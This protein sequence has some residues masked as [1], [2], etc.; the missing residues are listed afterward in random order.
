MNCQ[1]VA[2]L[3]R[4][5][6]I[7]GGTVLSLSSKLTDQSGNNRYFDKELSNEQ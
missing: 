5:K 7:R 1:T 3:L 2:K 6:S 4:H